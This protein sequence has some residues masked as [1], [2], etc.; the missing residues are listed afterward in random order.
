[1]TENTIRLITYLQSKQSPVHLKA[2]AGDLGISWQGVN[3]IFN[4]LVKNGYGE[5]IPKTV[6]DEASGLEKEIKLLV[7]TDL[8]YSYRE[9][10]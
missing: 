5:R 7:L 10:N 8:G 1:M 6:V 4:Q 3:A 9:Q 2:A